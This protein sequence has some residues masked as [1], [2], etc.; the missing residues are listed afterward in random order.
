MRGGAG[1]PNTRRPWIET[2]E[3]RRPRTRIDTPSAVTAPPK[4]DKDRM[5]IDARGCL[6]RGHLSTT[7]SEWTM[8]APPPAGYVSSPPGVPPRRERRTRASG[9]RRGNCN[10]TAAAAQVAPRG[11][12]AAPAT[13]ARRAVFTGVLAAIVVELVD[14]IVARVPAVVACGVT[15]VVDAVVAVVV[16]VEPSVVLVVVVVG[17]VQE[18]DSPLAV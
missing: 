4:S 14:A 13:R 17:V 11:R 5:A 3:R 1:L 18:V 7:L 6:R 9:S 10:S 2:R 15:V 12:T 8:I 16:S